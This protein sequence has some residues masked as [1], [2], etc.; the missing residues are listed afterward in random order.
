MNLVGAKARHKAFGSGTITAFEPSNA[1]G[2][3][4]YVTV[5]FAAKTAKFLYPD[6]FGKF[7][8]LEDEEANAKIVSAV[9]DEQ[10]AREKEQNIAKIKEALKLKA[11]KAEASAQKAKPK[12]ASKN[13]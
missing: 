3:S 6:A 13:S 9:E 10:K 5:E 4:G 7:I 11:E 8:V 12:A 2:T 1:E